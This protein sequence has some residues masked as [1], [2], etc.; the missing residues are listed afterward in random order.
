MTPPLSPHQSQAVYNENSVVTDS[1]HRTCAPVVVNGTPVN[2]EVESHQVATPYRPPAR[3]LD[4]EMAH[5][6]P[7]GKLKLTDFEV[8]G[9]L[10]TALLLV[11][12]LF[13]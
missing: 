10:G 8:K 13:I 2:M 9:T 3:S 7:P 11:T 12:P 6:E 4:D 1:H 5:V